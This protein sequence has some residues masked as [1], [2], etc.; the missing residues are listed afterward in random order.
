MASE[1]STEMVISSN[2]LLKAMNMEQEAHQR[3]MVPTGVLWTETFYFL[4]NSS[5]LMQVPFLGKSCFTRGPISCGYN[6]W[7]LPGM[8]KY[9]D[10]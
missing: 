6:C 1:L 10:F 8:A 2:F 7:L 4:L 3:G 9:F 5:E